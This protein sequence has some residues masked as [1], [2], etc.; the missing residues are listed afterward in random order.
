MKIDPEARMTIKTLAQK[1][2]SNRETARLLGICEGTVR[3]HRRRQ[4]EGV[5]DG[6]RRQPHRAKA[7]G[8]AIAEWLGQQ[9]ERPWNL[10]A[11]HGAD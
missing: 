1:G 9:A 2:C 6:R 8:E 10:A 3:Y 5:E 4:V 11:L 7:W